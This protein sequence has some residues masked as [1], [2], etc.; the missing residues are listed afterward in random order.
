MRALSTGDVNGSFIV[1]PSAPTLAMETVY[2]YG[3]L[4]TVV[5]R[6]TNPGSGVFER[7]IVWSSSPNPTLS[8]NKSVVGKGGF[9]FT[10]NFGGLTVG[11]QYYVKA[12]ARTS[13]GVYYSPEIG[14]TPIPDL[15]CPGIPSV[16][17]VDGNLY[18]TVQIGTQCW[19]QSN[20]KVSKYRNGDGI[21]T[22]LSNTNWLN[23]ISGSFA[24]YNNDPL[25]DG[26]YGKLYNHYAVMDSRGLCPTGWHVP[27]DSEWDVMVKYLDP[28]ADTSCTSCIQ[29]WI[30]GGMLKSISTEPLIGGWS[31]PNAGADNSS[32]FTAVPGGHRDNGGGFGWNGY[33]TV[34]WT[35]TVINGPPNSGAS[36][37]YLYSSSG[38]ISKTY[39]H[40]FPTGLSVR[41]LRDSVSSG[42]SMV[43]PTV[44]TSSFTAVT[45][46]S[47]T[48]GGD[49]VQDGGAP[50]TARGVAYGTSSS[51]TTT[52]TIT[53]DG[54]GTGVF[55][56]TLAGLT[57]STTYYVRAYATN[58][59]GTAYGN[60]VSFTTAPLSIGMS[61]AGGIVFDLDSTGQHGMVC[62][63][64]DQGSYEWGCIGT[65]IP[66]ISTAVGTGA[67]NSASIM[68]GCTQRPIA[69][70][71]CADLV[72]NGYSDW[73][74]PSLGELQLM[75]S[76]LHT[77]GIGGFTND[78]YW[79]S[80]QDG[81]NYA[82]RVF[83]DN[84][85]AYTG[86]KDRSRQVRAVRAF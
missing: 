19:T 70:S 78:Y 33:A 23:S 67:I 20:L 86:I 54:T 38:H 59:V 62:A 55:T 56:S 51:P 39:A 66:N 11:L 46:N 25:N 42:T 31:L 44:T 57:P 71:V 14:F 24:I 64:S 43:I 16:T 77:Q 26:L 28:I 83:F 21:P 10:H 63:P 5:V 58:S 74:L 73:Y 37:R 32:G 27:T 69:A 45:S 6:F 81:A 29:S 79:S 65:Q 1:Q 7:G 85:N 36:S 30:A 3:N 60:E 34:L 22:G 75:Y 9:G 49:V 15:P 12:Y 80:S 61:Y 53:N 17:D 47:A 48:T 72:L 4:G 76:N 8:S 82:W 84:G 50:V 35:S 18:H 41:C 52:G 68:A 40:S 2:G 13:A